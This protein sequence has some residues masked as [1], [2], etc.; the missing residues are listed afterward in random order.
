LLLP[1]S[2]PTKST[3]CFP[4]A[5]NFLSTGDVAAAR[6]ALRRAAASDDPQAALALGGTYDP[7]VL[8]KLGIVAF[9]ADAA[10]VRE[11][12]RK[13]AALGSAEASLRLE[14]LPAA[15]NQK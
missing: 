12:S 11:W 14:Q 1:I 7:S 4:V 2:I 3:P 9:H 5:R 6:V 13:A 10:L 8:K 15:E